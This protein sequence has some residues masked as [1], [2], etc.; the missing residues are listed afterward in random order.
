MSNMW[1]KGGTSNRGN[2]LIENSLMIDA[3]ARL[4]QTMSAGTSRRKFT[5]SFWYKRTDLS[6]TYNR[7]FT[8]QKDAN[9]WF[10]FRF[11]ADRLEVLDYVSAAYVT[12]KLSTPVFRDVSQHYHIFLVVDTTQATAANRVRIYVNNKEIVD[13]DSNTIIAQNGDSAMGLA[14]VV[15]GYYTGSTTSENMGGYISE[16]VFLDGTAATPDDFGEWHPDCPQ[17]WRPKRLS[18]LD[19][20][21]NNTHYLNFKDDTS[22]TTLGYDVSGNA[23]HL[24][25]SGGLAVTDQSTDTPTNNSCTMSD[26]INGGATLSEGALKITGAFL[27]RVHSAWPIP[28]G[29][30]KWYMEY[31]IP[32]AGDTML[33]LAATNHILSS[34]PGSDATSWGWHLTG[35]IYNNASASAFGT[36]FTHGDKLMMAYDS[37]THKLWFGKNG[38]WSGNPSAGTGQARTL[39]AGYDYYVSIRPSNVVGT[40]I[41]NENDFNYTPPTGFKALM[42]KNLPVPAIKDPKDYFDIV[43]YTGNATASRAITTQNKVDLLAIK[44]R[45]QADEWKVLDKNRGATKELS[46]DS[47]NA[48]ETD[49]NGVTAIGGTSGFTL[50]TGANGYNDNNED[51]VAYSWTDSATAG[52]DI[53][54]YTGNGVAGRTVSHALG[55]VPELMI[56][57]NKDYNLASWAVYHKDMAT[58]PATGSLILD[59][60]VAFTTSSVR[61]NDTEPTSSVFSVGTSSWTNSNNNVYEAYLFASVEGFSK[62]FEYAGNGDADGPPVYCEFKPALIIFKNSSS[63]ASWLLYDIKRNTL[64]PMDTYNTPHLPNSEGT[65]IACDALSNGFKIRSTSSALNTNTSI[66]VGIAFAEYPFALLN[67]GE[68]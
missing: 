23:N 10:L 38:T 18:G 41:F 4:V 1:Q 49:T 16:Y 26:I 29:T 5:F 67:N 11:N 9:N 65:L 57:K 8:W 51:F 52:I 27:G 35:A 19:F 53:I 22:A 45:D 14:T 63:A 3:D 47:Q 13:W 40:V 43:L 36:T 60:N 12:I 58:S 37:D 34:Y 20:S 50:G 21:G 62:V 33:G 25:A 68:L 30:G 54:Q 55:V 39:T 59:T 28:E 2:Y 64:N 32:T 61:W 7:L 6:R 46:W 31:D 24:A 42:T 15:S 56:V 48:N 66:Y 44:N 17:I